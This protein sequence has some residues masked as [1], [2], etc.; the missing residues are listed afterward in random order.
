MSREGWWS[1]GTGRADKDKIVVDDGVE[2]QQFAEGGLRR[3]HTTIKVYFLTY[4]HVSCSR[5]GYS[6][7]K[8]CE[9]IEHSAR[10]KQLV[11]ASGDCIF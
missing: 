7:M 1:E 9:I 5:E 6:V 10:C 8:S 3:D 4:F 2:A 11:A